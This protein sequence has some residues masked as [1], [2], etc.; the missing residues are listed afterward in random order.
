LLICHKSVFDRAPFSF[1]GSQFNL[2]YSHKSA[3]GEGAVL[4]I[5][6]GADLHDYRAKMGTDL[7]GKLIACKMGLQIPRGICS[8]IQAE[9]VVWKVSEKSRGDIS[10]FMRQRGVELMEG[11]LRPDHVQMCL[12][13]PPKYSVAPAIGFLKGKSAVR[14]HRE[15]LNNERVTGLHFWARGYCVSTVGL[16]EE[17]IKKYIREQEDNGKK[18]LEL[19]LE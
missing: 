19:D 11:H 3:G 18:Q 4:N 13:I 5:I 16:D 10:A 15:I 8:E 7:L 12:K 1:T 9:E 6:I 2:K 14:I 17:T